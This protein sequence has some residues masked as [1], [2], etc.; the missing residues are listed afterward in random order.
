MKS[1]SSEESDSGG[2]AAAHGPVPDG[3]SHTAQARTFDLPKHL[4]IP[5]IPES[6]FPIT[7][8]DDLEGKIFR[9]LLQDLFD[10]SLAA[11]SPS[12]AVG[13]PS[14]KKEDSN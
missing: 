7:S 12:A 2:L 1:Q 6:L 10:S 9:L 5:R 8:Q 3:G 14:R 4:P 11:G 13:L